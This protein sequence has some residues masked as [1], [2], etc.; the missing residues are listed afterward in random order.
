MIPDNAADVTDT[1]KKTGKKYCDNCSKRGYR[2]Y[3]HPY[4][5]ERFAIEC[6]ECGRISWTENDVKE[7]D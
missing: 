6:T 3:Q 4:F 7:K 5:P 1:H 2:I